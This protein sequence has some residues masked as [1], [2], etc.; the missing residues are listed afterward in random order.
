MNKRR[1]TPSFDNKCHLKQLKKRRNVCKDLRNMQPTSLFA[2]IAKHKETACTA[3]LVYK[4]DEVSEW[5]SPRHMIQPKDRFESKAFHSNPAGVQPKGRL[6][7]LLLCLCNAFLL[8][9]L[10]FCF[11]FTLVYKTEWVNEW[12]SL[13]LLLRLLLLC[14]VLLLLCFC[15]AFVLL[16]L[17]FCFAFASLLLCFVKGQAKSK[18]KTIYCTSEQNVRG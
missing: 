12:V 6:L 9:L 15:Y 16:L 11:A 8:L 14:F 1:D 17:C 13:F 18:E 7:L 10:C 3:L 2:W 5:E 4:N